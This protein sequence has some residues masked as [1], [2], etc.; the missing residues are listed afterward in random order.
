MKWY[1]S[2]AAARAVENL[3]ELSRR[4]RL[5]GADQAA[6]WVAAAPRDASNT[7]AVKGSD[8]HDLAER[9]AR[10]E[11][12]PVDLETDVRAMLAHYETF[13][14]DWQPVITRAE[15]TVLNRRLGYGGTCDAVM[16]APAWSGLPLVCDYKTGRTGPY[17]EW[18]V[19]LAAY[20]HGEAVL[21]RVKA[22]R[23]AVRETPMPAVDTTRAL[24]LRVR[25]DGY[26]LHEADLTGLIDVFASMLAVHAFTHDVEP[27]RRRLPDTQ[28]GAYWARRVEAAR[29]VEDLHAVW[30]EAVA[31]SA[32]DDSL[33]EQCRMRK[34]QLTGGAA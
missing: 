30:V 15:M 5:D 16:T 19:Q 24:I 9:H 25:P 22:G 7:A 23:P 10:G 11:A 28:T 32:W 21:E 8:L 18:A 29:A 12:L 20:A 26:E 17:P 4:V 3:A 6:A 1:A 33:L 27:F 34:M 2:R 14:S 13:L 31:A